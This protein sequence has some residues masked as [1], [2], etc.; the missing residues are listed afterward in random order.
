MHLAAETTV[1]CAL[2]DV[3]AECRTLIASY[4]APTDL[5][6]RY[7]RCCRWMRADALNADL[8]QTRWGELHVAQPAPDSIVIEGAPAAKIVCIESLLERLAHPSFRSAWRAPRCH[9]KIV[10]HDPNGAVGG[11]DEM[12]FEEMR[13][14]AS[15]IAFGDVT[16][17]DL[18]LRAIDDVDDG[19]DTSLDSLHSREHD[20]GVGS[21]KRSTSNRVLPRSLPWLL[22]SI[23]PGLIELDF[24]NLHGGP[25][26][27]GDYISEL[28]LFNSTNC[29]NIQKIRWD[30]RVGGCY[31]VRGK[32]MKT[33]AHL[34]ELHV[35]NLLAD[36]RFDKLFAP[37]M[38][39]FFDEASVIQRF[40]FFACNNNLER[41]SLKGGQYTT[42]EGKKVSFPQFALMRFVRQTPTLRWFRSD[43][44]QENIEK[45]SRERPE[46]CFCS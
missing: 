36:W 44:S 30:N 13:D 15:E 8:P 28:S 7:G 37:L 22:A 35:D 12:S 16:S 4:L 23:L 29:P 11:R 26:H 2:R 18:S 31:F 38:N 10:G 41:M 27:E 6:S 21:D 34:R 20:D 19:S 9:M 3:P 43:L 25:I 40:F 39:Q 46:I 24:T 42:M 45:L 5:Y 32:D 1:E 33:L 17:L 14:L